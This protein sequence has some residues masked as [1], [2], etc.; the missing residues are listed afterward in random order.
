MKWYNP[1]SRD[2]QI[3]YGECVFAARQS[4]CK[5]TGVASLIQYI[6][7]GNTN[8]INIQPLSS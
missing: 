3:V 4:T 6:C 1:S 7:S 5:T 2:W 8:G